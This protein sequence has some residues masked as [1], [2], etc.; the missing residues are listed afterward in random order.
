MSDFTDTRYLKT[1]QYK[2][3]SHYGVRVRFH[4]VCSQN[5]YGSY[6]WVMDH[7]RDRLSPDA[8]IL[9]LGGG[10]GDLWM[11]DRDSIPDDWTVIVSD[12]SPGMLAVAAQN[13]AAY[14]HS[15]S[16][17]DAQAIPF[18]AGRFDAVVA[19]LMLYHVPD[20]ERA[21]REIRRVL[22]PGGALFAMTLGEAHMS[23]LYDWVR[24]AMPSLEFSLDHSDSPFS[25][26]NG[27]D[28]L[29]LQFGAV[30]A[31]RYDDFVRITDTE[32]LRH[33]IASLE[34]KSRLLDDSVLSEKFETVARRTIASEGAIRAA[35]DIGMFIASGY[36]EGTGS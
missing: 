34:G 19:N 4:E 27:V 21:I 8:Q 1:Q 10:R 9:E 18:S 5:V 12:F 31:V 14:R 15:Y 35:K 7:L 23:E 32:L 2:D 36:S 20:R 25:L 30:D 24:W 29:K 26:E 22:K 16:V 13:L 17:V 11:L 28:Q 6:R 3:A 33:Y